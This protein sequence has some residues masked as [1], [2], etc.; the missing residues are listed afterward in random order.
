MP[1]PKAKRKVYPAVKKAAGKVRKAA[2]KVARK[3]SAVRPPEVKI[4]YMPQYRG[5]RGPSAARKIIIHANPKSGSVSKEMHFK[6][7]GDWV[8]ETATYRNPGRKGHI[9]VYKPT[10][11]LIFR[12]PDAKNVTLE[13]YARHAVAKLKKELNK[14][15]IS[16]ERVINL[17]Y[18]SSEKTRT[19][20]SVYLIGYMKYKAKQEVGRRAKL[21]RLTPSPRR[22]K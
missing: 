13:K 3:L 22:S 9:S 2:I 18:G 8:W 15:K 16:G 14:E 20:L 12:L 21:K 4:G 17:Y 19:S 6:L 1:G 11:E 5:A 7:N 10:V